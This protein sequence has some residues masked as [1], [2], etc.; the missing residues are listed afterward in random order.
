MALHVRF[1]V[2]ERRACLR[3]ACI[4]LFG[5]GLLA[6]A[7]PAAAQ[8]TQGTQVGQMTC[9]QFGTLRGTDR[10]LFLSWLYGYYAG[11]AQKPAIDSGLFQQA[12]QSMSAICEK[13][14]NTPMIGDQMRAVFLPGQQKP[15][16]APNQANVTAPAQQGGSG[17]PP[18]VSVPGG[19][20]QFPSAGASE[21]GQRIAIPQGLPDP[22]TTGS[23]RPATEAESRP[24]P[25]PS[26]SILDMLFGK[27]G[28]DQ[29]PAKPRPE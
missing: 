23:V 1:H 9:A 13:A 16:E 11:A 6:P 2:S 25:A 12:S 17:G 8:G 24:A 20:Q 21:G 4:G 19:A 28:Q 29:V 15:S 10:D 14:P 7:L 22:Q 18:V 3:F 27:A 5:L 26:R